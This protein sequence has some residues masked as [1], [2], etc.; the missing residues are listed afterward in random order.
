VARSRHSVI[1]LITIGLLM[2]SG[3]G[4]IARDD[5]GTLKV[6]RQVRSERMLTHSNGEY[7]EE[8][9]SDGLLSQRGLESEGGWT[10]N[11]A[12]LSGD[13][14]LHQ[15]ADRWCHGACDED[16]DNELA[17]VQ[18]G[19]IEVTNDGGTWTGTWVAPGGSGSYGLPY[20]EL[21]GSGGYA[22]LSAI[23]VTGIEEDGREVVN[24][25]IIPGDVPPDR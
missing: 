2:D 23:L 13:I 4:A 17:A 19:T 21:V 10:F 20:Y 6:G 1:V 15:N 18:W 25:V 9:E 22:G 7:T 12:R 8:A 16:N 5:D 24:G 11:D 14:T 3:V